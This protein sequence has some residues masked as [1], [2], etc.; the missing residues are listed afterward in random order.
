MP[1]TTVPAPAEY[2]TDTL[3]IGAGQ[4]GLAAAY[5]L[6]RAGVACLLVDAAAA[7]GQQ[8]ATRYDSLRLF[9][10]AWASGLPGLPWP[11]AARRYP[12]KDEAAEYLRQYAAYFD[13]AIHLNQA[14]VHLGSAK[15]GFEARTAAGTR[16]RARRVIVCTGGYAAP[17]VP[18]WAA[19]LPPAVVQLH[20]SAYR[21]PA[22][23]PAGPVAVVGSG[24]SALQ[25]A[26]DLAAAGRAVY[27]AFDARTGAMPNNTLM[28]AALEATGLM[29]AS[30]HGLLGGWMR[31]QPEPV[32]AGDLQRLRRFANVHFIGRARGAAAASLQGEAAVTPALA[33]VVWATGYGPDYSW[34][35][36]PVLDAD[37][38]PQHHRGLSPVPGLAFLGLPWLDSRSSALMG[39]A[40]RDAHRVVTSL[41]GAETL[42]GRKKG[43]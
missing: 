42:V 15:E 19:E 41:L 13:F 6:Q 17:R 16:Y 18:A 10:P 34:L 35:D 11:G 24:N 7:V 22:Q 8:W 23:L 4:A 39:G 33:A 14:V 20:S 40:G 30:R 37:G 26:A 25:I 1:L 28:W 29:R 32:V 12:T 3:I 21:R 5:Y 31:R 2:H 38:Q 9:S 43:N 36:L 27:A